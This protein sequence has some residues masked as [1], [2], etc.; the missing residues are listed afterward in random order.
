MP[1]PS[2]PALVVLDGHDSRGLASTILIAR[3]LLDHEDL[4]EAQ[5]Q[6][7]LRSMARAATSLAHLVTAAE[8]VDEPGD[9]ATDAPS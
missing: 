4:D 1:D 7:I 8:G 9:L 2:P 5:R 6:T 3:G